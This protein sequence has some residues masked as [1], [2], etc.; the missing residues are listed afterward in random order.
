MDLN[1]VYKSLISDVC[2]FSLSEYSVR[3]FRCSGCR[4]DDPVVTDGDNDF[5]CKRCNSR[6][7]YM[8]YSYSEDDFHRD[9]QYV[10]EFLLSIQLYF[11]L[12]RSGPDQDLLTSVLNIDVN[13]LTY[14][15]FKEVITNLYTALHSSRQD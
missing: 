6:A 10:N 15:W 9:R 8:L 13:S 2:L 12:Y 11:G 7:L 1:I 14:Q 4:N 3:K 5:S